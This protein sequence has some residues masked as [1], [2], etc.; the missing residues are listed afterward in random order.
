MNGVLA[1]GTPKKIS[2]A[3]VQKVMGMQN[4]E[5]LAVQQKLL[6]QKRVHSN[7]SELCQSLHTCETKQATKIA[8]QELQQAAAD[9]LCSDH[10]LCCS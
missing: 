6:Q 4:Q 7:P 5:L 1:A 3:E 2:M 9:A 8:Q 10:R